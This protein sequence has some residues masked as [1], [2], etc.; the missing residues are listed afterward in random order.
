LFF[1]FVGS[2][3]RHKAVQRPGS[4]HATDETREVRIMLT[5]FYPLF[6]CWVTCSSRGQTIKI[7][8]WGRAGNET[9]ACQ[10]PQIFPFASVLLHSQHCTCSK[11][12]S[13]ARMKT[14]S[15]WLY[16]RI[17]VSRAY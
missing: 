13:H 5:C 17:L 3:V 14:V 11:T 10:R 1:D 15:Q 8:R 6:C 2:L 9:N 4:S 16:W 12:V 7:W